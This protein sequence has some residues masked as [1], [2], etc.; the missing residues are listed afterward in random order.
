MS[1]LLPWTRKKSTGGPRLPSGKPRPARPRT[2]ARALRVLLVLVGLAALFLTVREALLDGTF[3]RPL[4]G[5][6]KVWEVNDLECSGG[7]YVVAYEDGWAFYGPTGKIVSLPE[8]SEQ[9]VISDCRAYATAG[10]SIH[11]YG[12][13]GR[14]LMTQAKEPGERLLPCR[15]LSGILAIRPS[16]SSYGEPWALRAISDGGEVFPQVSLPGI[17]AEAAK[18]GDRLYI[19][20]RDIASG[21]IA[22]LACAEIASGNVLWCVPLG[23]GHWRSIIP[24]SGGKVLYVTSQ[25]AG[26]VGWDGELTGSLAASGPIWTAAWEKGNVI[27]GHGPSKEP[28]ITVF[29]EDGQVAWKRKTPSMAHGLVLVDDALV[30]LCQT[31]VIGFSL[32]DGRRVFSFST[33]D[34]PLAM[35]E[36]LVLFRNDKGAYLLSLDT[37]LSRLP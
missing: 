14:L 6:S 15:G 31:H 24:L 7:L 32:R 13:D 1:V 17:P 28:L 12:S 4:P 3:P 33:R 27:L 21:G 18:Q 22:R 8:G 11:G 29:S 23:S 10:S 2:W 9:A 36:S 5:G 20:L 34:L 19:G 35:G 25:S 26:I 37:S 30:A 16:G